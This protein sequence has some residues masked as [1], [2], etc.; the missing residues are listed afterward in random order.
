MFRAGSQ[1]RCSITAKDLDSDPITIKWDVRPD[2]AN[3]PSSGGDFEPAARPLP[4]S[5]KEQA[6]QSAVIRVP[7]TPGSYRIFVYV[8]NQHNGAATANLPIEAK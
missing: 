3:N 5:I 2:V 8:Y 6:N 1:I 4:Q 7:S